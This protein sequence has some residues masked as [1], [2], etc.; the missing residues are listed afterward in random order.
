[1]TIV[2]KKKKWLA[3]P[4]GAALTPAG[5]PRY[6][7]GPIQAA[8]ELYARTATA[9]ARRSRRRTTA[10]DPL[11]WY[12]K[13]NNTLLIFAKD[14]VAGPGLTKDKRLLFVLKRKVTRPDKT[15]GLVQFADQQT[16][17]M[18]NRIK[19]AL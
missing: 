6:P 8:Q 19:G 18:I 12:K 5:A 11:S 1:M 7:G 13:D 3:I 15:K 4:T 17:V 16:I 10:R 2:P 9:N 14:G